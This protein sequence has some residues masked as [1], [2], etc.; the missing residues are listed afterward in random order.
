MGSSGAVRSSAWIWLFSS[1]HSTSA[2]S[3]GSRYS[4]TMSRTLSINNGSRLSL[5]L[6]LRCGCSA[7]ARQMRLTAVW[8]MPLALA[9]SRVDQCVAALGLDSRVRVRTR[10]TS[11]S[12]I[13]RGCPGRG[14]SSS[15]STPESRNR[16]HHFADRLQTHLH[17]GGNRGGRQPVG[18]AQHDA[19]TKRQGLRRFPPPAPVAQRL[20][21]LFAQHQ[22]RQSASSAHCNSSCHDRRNA[23]IICLTN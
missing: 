16:R 11:A 9:I 15:P 22:R 21:A 13:L 4:P 2:R 7:K 18:G 3:G 19:R 23:S 1:T 12:A 20:A 14:S 10:S 5:K 8:L 17:L 6:S